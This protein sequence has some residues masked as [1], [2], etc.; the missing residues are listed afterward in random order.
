[1]ED[2]LQAVK[3]KDTTPGSIKSEEHKFL[4]AMFGFDCCISYTTAMLPKYIPV[5]GTTKE[6][7]HKTL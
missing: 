2:H 5:I 1:M 3:N 6:R 4:P 7:L